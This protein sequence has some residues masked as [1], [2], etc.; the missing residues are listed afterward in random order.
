MVHKLLHGPVNH[1]VRYIMPFSRFHN[2][3]C[4]R[5]GKRHGNTCEFAFNRQ[6]NACPNRDTT[7]HVNRQPNRQIVSKHGLGI[8]IGNATGVS[9]F[10]MQSFALLVTHTEHHN[11]VLNNNGLQL[12]MHINGCLSG[13]CN[14]CANG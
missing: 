14:G 3:H 6:F 8:P 13:Y 7:V 12:T 10:W 2:R 4:I 9:K 5:C 11:V 1:M